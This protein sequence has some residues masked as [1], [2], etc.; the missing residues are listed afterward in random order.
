MDSGDE[1]RNDSLCLESKGANGSD[2]VVDRVHDGS[3]QPYFLSFETP[4]PICSH[5]NRTAVH[6]G[7]DPSDPQK[8]QSLRMF[9]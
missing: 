6:A 1:H 4:A 8:T 5:L 3:D 2:G 7:G 9:A